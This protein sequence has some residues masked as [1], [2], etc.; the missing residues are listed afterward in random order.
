MPTHPQCST[1]STNPRGLRHNCPPAAAF[2]FPL[3]PFNFVGFAASLHASSSW[4]A[5]VH[6]LQSVKCPFRGP[7]RYP[8]RRCLR[9][10]GAGILAQ[11]FLSGSVDADD[12]AVAD[13]QRDHDLEA[14]FE[15]R[16][17]P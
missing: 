5:H 3:S 12:V 10:I 8:R 14:S 1:P 11:V 4:A 15:L 6:S 7:A 9:T 17:L 2:S 13:K 16:L